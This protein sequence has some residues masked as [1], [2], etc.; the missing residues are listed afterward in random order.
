MG[1]INWVFLGPPIAGKKGHLTG[2]YIKAVATQYIR[3]YNTSTDPRYIRVDGVYNMGASF[4]QA[5]TNSAQIPAG[6]YLEIKPAAGDGV[7]IHNIFYEEQIESRIVD[8]SGN[9][10]AFLEAQGT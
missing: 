5:Y 4:G 1:N 7:I 6:N 3:I 2:L 9:E 10:C 8:A